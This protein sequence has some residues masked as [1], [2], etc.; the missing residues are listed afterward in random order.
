MDVRVNQTGQ[1]RTAFDIKNG[2]VSSAPFDAILG[3]RGGW[4]EARLRTA[5]AVR[6]VES[7]VVP[8]TALTA[9]VGDGSPLAAD[10]VRLD[11][12]RAV[13]VRAIP[14]GSLEQV[15]FR[16]D[17]LH[18]LVRHGVAVINSPRSVERSVDKY[19]TSTLLAEAGLPT[20]R[21]VVCERFDDALGA[22]ADLGRD[23][24]VKPIFGAEGRGI[25]R[26]TDADELVRE[27]LLGDRLV[28]RLVD[29]IMQ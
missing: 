2:G 11:R 5:L 8:I 1:Y 24:V 23:V 27:H 16:V 29:N 9:T 25:V 26:V 7:V 18:R 14:P 3:A 22:F 15:I 21:T 13:L 28:A 12:C 4:H 17:A 6:G 19:F 10:G 20:P